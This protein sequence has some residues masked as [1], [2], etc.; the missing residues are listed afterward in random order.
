MPQQT[1]VDAG[2]AVLVTAATGYIGAQL[3]A[4]LVEAGYRV[5][6]SARRPS[7]VR[8]P[9]AVEVVAADAFD[10]EATLASLQGIRH[11]VLPRAHAGSRRRLRRPR[12]RRRRDLREGSRRRGRRAHRVPRW[13]GGG[14]PGAL[15]APLEPPRGR[16]HPRVHRRPRRR[17]PRVDRRWKRLDLVRDDPQSGREA[18][19]DDHAPMGPPA[20]TADLDPGCS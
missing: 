20:R 13:I 1:A 6:A 14:T 5:R 12:P 18:S 8:A 19:R 10:A 4:P 16:A 11:R 2:S 15:G 3:L 9:Q 17:V 7:A